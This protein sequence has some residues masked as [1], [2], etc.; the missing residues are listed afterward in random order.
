MRDIDRM[1]DRLRDIGESE[2][3]LARWLGVRH[4]VIYNWK[5]RG[6]IPG[7]RRA[8]VARFL[9]VNTD[10]L[11]TGSGP[12]ER[13]RDPEASPGK[14]AEDPARPSKV[15]EISWNRAARALEE[16]DRTPPSYAADWVE[17][18]V[19]VRPR[20]FALRVEGESMVPR[21]PPGVR[22]IVEPELVPREGDYVVARD[23]E[24]ATTLRQLVRD[25]GDWFLKPL[26]S[27]Y[28]VK[29]LAGWEIIGVVREAVERFR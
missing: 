20:A 22:I 5:T 26:N 19:Q 12:K 8:D 27:Q 13:H 21:F 24:D 7:D 28:P 6:K 2:A 10:W 15:P 17:T 25:G 4:Q 29:P 9:E 16:T 23:G 11:Q 1:L 18:A 3:N 14:I